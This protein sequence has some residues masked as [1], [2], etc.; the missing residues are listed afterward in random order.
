M[1]YCTYFQAL[2]D[3][4]QTWLLTASLRSFEY[5]CFDR[6]I[7]K[8]LGRFEFFVPSDLKRQF[9]G[10]MD[11]FQQKGIVK[12]LHEIENRLLDPQAEL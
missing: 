9:L 7:D 12:D 10:V 3:R 1:N 2:V 4:E 11:Y 6:T 8:K 5:L